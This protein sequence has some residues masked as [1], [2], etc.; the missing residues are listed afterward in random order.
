VLETNLLSSIAE[1]RCE[2]KRIAEEKESFDEG[3]P[4][5]TVIMDGGWS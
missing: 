1:A 2:E 3:V 5:S 4:A